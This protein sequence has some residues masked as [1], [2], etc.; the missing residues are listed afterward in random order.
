MCNK[1]RQNSSANEFLHHINVEYLKHIGMWRKKVGLGMEASARRSWVLAE[2][3]DDS[4]SEKWV[5]FRVLK[6]TSR[7][8][9]YMKLIFANEKKWRFFLTFLISLCWFLFNYT[10]HV[11][12][13]RITENTLLTNHHCWPVRKIWHKVMLYN[14]FLNLFLSYWR[15]QL[16]WSSEVELDDYVR[17]QPCISMFIRII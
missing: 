1:I 12:I 15:I 8:I 10:I 17:S 13:F 5:L 4:F 2:D 3:E 9:K 7:I 14:F 16:L 6:F 11:F